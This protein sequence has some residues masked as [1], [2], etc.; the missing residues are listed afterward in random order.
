[1]TAAPLLDVKDLEQR[2]ALPRESLFRAPGQVRALNGV[3]VQVAAGKS[4]GVVGESGSGKSTFARLVMALERP[5]SGQVALLGRDLNRIPADEL[6]RARRDFQMVFQDPYGS[7]DPRQTIARIVAEPLTVLE[8][9]DRT[10]FR[11]RVAAVLRQ[12]GLRDADMEKYPHEFSGGQR[13]RIAIAR[14]LITQPK[15][16]VADEP[17]SA[18][19]VSVQAQVLNLMQ[20][21]QEQFGLSYILISHDL[22]V[23]DYLCDEVAVMYL[24]RIV[25]QGRPE[26]LFEHCAHPYTRALLEAVPRAR[27]GGGRR[28]RGGQAIASQSAAAAGCPYAARC[29]LAEQH[30]REA[31]PALR[32]VGEGHLAACHRAE[33]VMALP[34]VAMEG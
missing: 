30:C 18:L 16:I 11:D 31:L 20:D 19:D 3:S 7:L 1:M 24:G 33:A 8:G 26:D 28:R 32:K 25:E 9:A 13:Q 6:R 29:P 23:V 15:L 17:V 10:T 4:L 27:A 34:Q 2:Y 22:A 14:A 5:T 21:L 12:V